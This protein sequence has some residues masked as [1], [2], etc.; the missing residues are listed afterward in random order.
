MAPASPKSNRRSRSRLSLSR[1]DYRLV[2]A[3]C[4][5]ENSNF[6]GVSPTATSSCAS[7]NSATTA[8]QG[9]SRIAP[10]GGVISKSA[11][12]YQAAWAQG[13]RSAWIA[14]EWRVEPERRSPTPEAVAAMEARVAAIRAGT[15]PELVWLLEHPPLYTAGTSARDERPDRSRPLPGL[16]RRPRR[17]LHL[18]RPGPARRLC[19]ARPRAAGGADVRCYVTSSRNGCIRALDALRRRR[20]APDRSR[21]HLGGDR[22]RARPRSPRSACASAAG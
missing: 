8:R 20:R 13:R 12:P 10:R 18:S 17:P 1:K 4:G 3:W 9:A 16:P 19:H 5:R 21:R 15:A 7:T 11:L 22:A 2:R 6:H 14:I